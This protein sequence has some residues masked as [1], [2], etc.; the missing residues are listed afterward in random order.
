MNTYQHKNLEMH[1]NNI[2]LQ[3]LIES[4]VKEILLEQQEDIV[5]NDPLV[6]IFIQPFTDVI[7]TANAEIKKNLI[8]IRGNTKSFIKQAAILAIP[9]LSIEMISDTHKAAQQEI[10]K[11]LGKIDKEY[12]EIYRRNW[13]TLRSRDIWGIGFM[14]NPAQGVAAKFAMKAP[15]A[16][17]NMLKTLTA[18]SLSEK[19]SERLQ[20][21]IDFAGKFAYHASPN[22][23]SNVSHGGGGYGS[24]GFDM[25]YFDGDQSDLGGEG[26]VY[27]SPKLIEQQQQT[28]QPAQINKQDGN[29]KI[30]AFIEAFAKQPDVQNAIQNSTIAKELRAGAMEAILNTA[31]PVLKSTTYEQLM[32]SLGSSA[33]KYEN[34]I[35]QILPKDL[36]PEEQTQFKQQLMPE[37]KKAYKQVLV[38]QL[39]KQKSGDKIADNNLLQIINQIN[40]A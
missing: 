3:Q 18:G 8:N 2:P 10:E 31:N 23:G 1:K 27:K 11:R 12:A 20:K 36:T 30:V 32:Q 9:F 21:A 34:E 6:K 15:R 26:V 33:K 25:G 4:I 7:K 39:S 28:N 13:E 40:K 24:G 37:I 29:K 5:L 16:T 22:Y 17:L 38:T 35:E 19:N 14:L